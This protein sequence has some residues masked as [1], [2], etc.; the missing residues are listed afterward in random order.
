MKV[1]RFIV[2]DAGVGQ[3]LDVFIALRCSGPNATNPQSR[4]GVQKL[5]DAG[6]VTVNGVTAKAS[7]R[8]KLRDHVESRAPEVRDIGLIG[9]ALPLIVLYEDDDILVVNKAAGMVVHPAAGWAN[10][11]LVNAILHH[12]PAIAGIGG[13]RRPGIVHRLDKDT[14]GVMVVAKSDLAMRSLIEQF[15]S[16][17]VHKEYLALVHGCMTGERGEIDRSIGRHRTERIRMSSLRVTGKRRQATT[18][19]AVEERYSF[20]MRGHNTVSSSLIRVAPRT[21]RTHQIRVHLA[22][23]GHPLVGDRVYGRRYPVASHDESIGGRVAGFPRHALHAATLSFD[24]VRGGARVSFS[25]PLADD[26][27]DLIQQLRAHSVTQFHCKEFVYAD[28]VDK[29]GRLK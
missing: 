28:G 14:S 10:G 15:K 29:V 23:L 9:E 4:A 12:C 25:A 6:H 11:T 13:E 19:W 5:I 21:G 24:P 16:R 22:D 8:L 2:D 18:H 20:M 26:L 17:I 27:A 1:D 7:L 3:R